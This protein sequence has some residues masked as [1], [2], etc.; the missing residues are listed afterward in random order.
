MP[1]LALEGLFHNV[2]PDRCSDLTWVEIF[3]FC[4]MLGDHDHGMRL[5]YSN[6]PTH[7]S[8]IVFSSAIHV[9]AIY[10]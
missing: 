6:P 9:Q 10:I 3:C 7:L 5:V 4:D 8:H 2:L 1:A